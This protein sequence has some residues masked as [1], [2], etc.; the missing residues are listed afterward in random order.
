MCVCMEGKGKLEWGCNVSVWGGGEGGVM[1][2]CVW[3][4]WG[5]GRQIGVGGVVCVWGEGSWSGGCNVSG[6]GG[7]A[8]RLEWGV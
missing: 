6:G 7:E 1:C 2:A 3:G 8:G 4:G 5:G